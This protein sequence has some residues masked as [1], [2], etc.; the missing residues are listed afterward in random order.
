MSA[1]GDGRGGVGLE[2]PSWLASPV[3][4]TGYVFAAKAVGVLPVT[5]RKAW[6]NAGTLA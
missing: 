6:E 2:P 4:R 1:G 3:A 5:C